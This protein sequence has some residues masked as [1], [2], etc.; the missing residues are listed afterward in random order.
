MSA[1]IGF[2]LTFIRDVNNVSGEEIVAL[3]ILKGLC[4]SELKKQLVIFVDKKVEKQLRRLY[5]NLKIVITRKKGVA[6]YKKFLRR[7]IRKNKLSIMFYPHASY[8]MKNKLEC[9]K[10]VVLHGVSSKDI[11]KRK[12]KKTVKFLKS[13]ESIVAVSDFVK[14]EL[15]NKNRKFDKEKITVILNPL[16]DL[17]VGVDIVYK[18]KYILCVGDNDSN[19]NLLSILKAFNEISGEIEHDL[20][21][22]GKLSEKEKAYKYIKKYGFAHRVIVTGHMNRDT[23]FGYYK[24]ADLFVNA[25]IY[26]GFGLTPI[27][28]LAT[29]IRV[30][31]T[32]T[33]S[34]EA[35]KD[36]ECEGYINKPKDYIDISEIILM[37]LQ[38]PKNE[39]YLQQRATKVKE[40]YNYKKVIS[41]YEALIK[42]NIGE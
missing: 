10:I 13:C 22:I 27:E 25:S 35:I 9:K 3:Y 2:D 8:Q 37:A 7:Y 18:K 36:I 11:S 40:F 1:K 23:L 12:I 19:K 24:N 33:P 6:F 14:N 16:A 34:I 17:R 31:T 20:V 39:K 41:K 28:A 38:T 21:I 42:K 26:D 5:K 4:E 15:L 30:V 32:I 29:G